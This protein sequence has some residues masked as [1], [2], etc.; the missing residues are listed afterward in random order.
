M[1]HITSGHF[2]MH[3]IN[4]NKTRL[5]RYPGIPGDGE[6]WQGTIDLLMKRNVL[7]LYNVHS[8]LVIAT[9]VIN[10]LSINVIKL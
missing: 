4:N 2:T 8:L 3:Q 7:Q 5:Q 6:I 10:I 9:V 1:E